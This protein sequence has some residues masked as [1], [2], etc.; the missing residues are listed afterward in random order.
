M[1][2]S[3]KTNANRVC[4]NKVSRTR[5]EV[6]CAVHRASHETPEQT[7][8]REAAE[9][10]YTRKWL[11]FHSKKAI[12]S[13]PAQTGRET[14]METIWK[15]FWETAPEFPNPEEAEAAETLADLRIPQMF[16]EGT[17][18]PEDSPRY[19]GTTSFRAVLHQSVVP[20]DPTE[21]EHFGVTEHIV[22]PT[23][24]EYYMN[25][26]VIRNALVQTWEEH[27]LPEQIIAEVEFL[28][29]DGEH[30]ML[31]LDGYH[32]PHDFDFPHYTFTKED[33]AYRNIFTVRFE[34]VM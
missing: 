14:T 22:E 34:R 13:R 30:V 31:V 26:S 25:L 29:K 18:T 9:A 23:H 5:A 28:S 3:A 4:K 11:E 2:C 1:R 20:L 7:A 16:D 24:Y 15:K 6:Y 10:D 8:R 12:L 17:I 19:W 32:V 27:K 33:H 21:L